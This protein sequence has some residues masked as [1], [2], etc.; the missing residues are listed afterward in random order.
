MRAFA[1]VLAEFVDRLRVAGF[2]A[3]VDASLLD[4]NPAAVWVQPREVLENRQTLR[5]W[6]YL[7]VGNTE[8]FRTLQLLDD[9]VE[10]LIELIGPLPDDDDVFDLAAAVLLPSSPTPFPAYRVRVDLDL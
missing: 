9:A 4:V 10:G 8:T 6:C 7:I 3:D 1:P 2:T 5:V